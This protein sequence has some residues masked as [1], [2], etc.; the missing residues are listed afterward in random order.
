MELHLT[1]SYLRRYVTEI[2]GCANIFVLSL[3]VSG[4]IEPSLVDDVI[5]PGKTVACVA[6]SDKEQRTEHYRRCVK[7]GDKITQTFPRKGEIF[8]SGTLL[9]NEE[10]GY[11]SEL[12]RLGGWKLRLTGSKTQE[13]KHGHDLDGSALLLA[14]ERCCRTESTA[15]RGPTNRS[16]RLAI[17]D[18]RGPTNRGSGLAITD[19]AVWRAPTIRGPGMA[20]TEPT[21]RRDPGLAPTKPTVR[22]DPAN[23]SPGLAPTEPG[24]WGGPTNIT[25]LAGSSATGSLPAPG[26]MAANNGASA[27]PGNMGDLPSVGEVGNLGFGWT[28]QDGSNFG[29]RFGDGFDPRQQETAALFQENSP[30]VAGPPQ[31][32]GPQGFSLANNLAPGGPFIDPTV[33]N[34][35]LTAPVPIGSGSFIG[36]GAP[37]APG[38]PGAQWS[39]P[40]QASPVVP[41]NN[42]P[43]M[44]GMPTMAPTGFPNPSRPFPQHISSFQNSGSQGIQRMPTVV[45][46]NHTPFQIPTFPGVPDFPGS[47][48]PAPGIRLPGAQGWSHGWSAP[49]MPLEGGAPITR[50]MVGIPD[51]A[52]PTAAGVPPRH[53]PMPVAFGPPPAS[54]FPNPAFAPV[55]PEGDPSG[56]KFSSHFNME[57]GHGPMPFPNPS[58]GHMK[59]KG[60]HKDFTFPQHE[61]TRKGVNIKIQHS[62]KYPTEKKKSTNI[63]KKKLVAEVSVEG[64]RRK[65]PVRR[66]LGALLFKGLFG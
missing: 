35:P 61:P 3:A 59:P 31:G 17:T 26:Q 46:P 44:G 41:V 21:V 25:G 50:G 60:T 4:F 27:G 51:V 15:S 14:C 43:P 66:L 52:F 34:N 47:S 58:F 56:V 48:D 5:S 57:V 24:V 12:S 33:G 42:N 40:N 55:K 11:A 10:R 54:S 16:S 62:S 63:V 36:R 2:D 37:M 30:P 49:S 45:P 38:V 13:H 18:W 8:Y 23:R 9:K 20:F 6:W 1:T 7:Q 19:R 39:F 32:A 29:Q 53:R 64:P 65:S 28:S 22:G